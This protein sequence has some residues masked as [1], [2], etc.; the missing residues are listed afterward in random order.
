MFIKMQLKD[1]VIFTLQSWTWYF[2]I[3]LKANIEPVYQFSLEFYIDLFERSVE[4]AIP[5]RFERVK[6]INNMFTQT[7]F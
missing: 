6:N 1:Q 4:K 3:I 5:G 7:L 2:L